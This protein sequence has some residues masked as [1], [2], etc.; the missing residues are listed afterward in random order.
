MKV[1]LSRRRRGALAGLTGA[2]ASAVMAVGL[3]APAQAWPWSSQ[4]KVWGTV[5]SCGVSSSAG[6]GWYSTGDG[7]SGWI[8]FYNGSGSFT[9]QLYRVPASGSVVTIKWGLNGCQA[10]RYRVIQRPAYGDSVSVG[11]LM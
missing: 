2:A 1:T 7:D 4:V 3:A 9:F 11:N 10:V 6:W 5:S 8:N